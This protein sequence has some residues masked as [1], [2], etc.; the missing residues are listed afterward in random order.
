MNT[1]PVPLLGVCEAEE[2]MSS[3]LV[4]SVC[5]E[6][7]TNNTC[8][9]P[10]NKAE[11]SVRVRCYGLAWQVKSDTAQTLLNHGNIQRTP[12]GWLAAELATVSE[13]LAR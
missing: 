6:H 13:T 7:P 4:N 12:Q 10:T 11:S 5:S 8:N 1:S 3:L 9:W 2:S